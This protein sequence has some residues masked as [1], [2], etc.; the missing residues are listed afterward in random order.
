MKATCRWVVATLMMLMVSSHVWAADKAD[1]DSVWPSGTS[2]QPH[3]VGGAM[4]GSCTRYDPDVG[5]SGVCGEAIVGLDVPFRVG[6]LS[7]RLDPEVGFGWSM[8]TTTGDKALGTQISSGGVEI[9][10]RP[11]VT[12]DITRLFFARLG[13]QVR[14][15]MLLDT[16]NVGVQGVLDLGTRVGSVFELGLRGYAGADAI[17]KAQAT[18]TEWSAAFGWGTMVLARFY[19]Q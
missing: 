11:L 7:M 15:S 16:F 9:S 17:E 14:M 8:Q 4:F 2:W 12:F 1:D 3:F 10:V 13:P 6:K 5:A 18:N 19:T